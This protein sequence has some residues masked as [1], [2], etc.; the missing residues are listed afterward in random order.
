MRQLTAEDEP[1]IFTLRSNEAV[2]KYLD[3]IKARSLEDARRFIN[4]VNNSIRNNEAIF[5]GICPATETTIIGTACLWNI[6]IQNEK[7]E[8]GYELLPAWQGKGLMQEALSVIIDFGFAYM[9]LRAIVAM[10]DQ[11]NERSVKL[12]EKHGFKREA[13]KKSSLTKDDET[14]NMI[15]YRLGRK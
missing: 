8:I 5:W 9:H 11:Q 4:K 12:L 7:A 3:R 10:A 13:N 2:N 6:D 15:T 14:S 1:A